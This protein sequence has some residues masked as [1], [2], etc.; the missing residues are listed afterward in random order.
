MSIIDTDFLTLKQLESVPEHHPPA[1]ALREPLVQ[2]V[3]HAGMVDATRRLEDAGGQIVHDGIAI[4]VQDRAVPRLVRP[5]RIAV[6][7]E[8]R[9]ARFGGQGVDSGIERV[10]ARARVDQRDEGS[11]GEQDGARFDVG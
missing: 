2:R 7:R 1:I 9:S 6:Q 5:A 3:R 8:I 11:L 10:G 4:A